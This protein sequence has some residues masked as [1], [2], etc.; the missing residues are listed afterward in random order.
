MTMAM[1]NP[2]LKV[3]PEFQAKIPP[4]TDEEYRQLEE[5]ILA[6]GEV[7]DAIVTWDGTIIDGHNRWK[8][9]QTHP[10]VNIKYRTREMVFTDRWEAIDWM[11]AHQ[12]GRRNLTE[13]QKTYLI[14][15]LYE[16]RKHVKRGAQIGNQFAVKKHNDQSGRNVFRE[17][18]DVIAYEQG[19]GTGTVIHAG[20]FARGI[21]A[22]RNI[23]QETA[24]NILTDKKKIT[25]EVVERIGAAPEPERTALITAVIE[26]KTLP[27]KK[28]PPKSEPKPTPPS[29]QPDTHTFSFDKPISSRTKAG[30]QLMSEIR[31]VIENQRN[32][33]IIKPT[34]SVVTEMLMCDVRAMIDR[35]EDFI[36]MNKNTLTEDLERQIN[37]TIKELNN[38]KGVLKNV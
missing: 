3:D 37:I 36:S 16:A 29:S 5:N 4:L 35:F 31:T 27:K 6:A 1:I 13:A 25:K 28:H 14:G 2:S 15:K 10:E 20:R 32:G 26:G 18:A 30:Q 33:E 34:L 17:T 21:D 12:L 22:I 8:I 23:S 19:V 38:L 11:Y 24:S 9:I 7:F